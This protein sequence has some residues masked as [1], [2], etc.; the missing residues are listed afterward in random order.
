M[1]RKTNRQK[2]IKDLDGLMIDIVRLRDNYTCQHCG[3]RVTK[4]NAHV[5]HVIPRSAGNKLRWDL[6]NLKVLCFHCHINWWHK[7]PTEAS[8]WFKSKFPERYKYLQ[9]SKGIAIYK[10]FQLELLKDNLTAI[11]KELESAG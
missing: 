3:K 8:E 7:N 2:V 9:A 5:S 4:K 6:Q 1:A 10:Q 11:L